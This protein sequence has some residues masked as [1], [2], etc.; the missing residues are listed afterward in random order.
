VTDVETETIMK[1]RTAMIF[2]WAGSL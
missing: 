1:V 2:T